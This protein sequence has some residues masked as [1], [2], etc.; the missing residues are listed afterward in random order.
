MFGKKNLP[1][2]P[3]FSSG[4]ARLLSTISTGSHCVIPLHSVVKPLFGPNFVSHFFNIKQH[5]QF[6]KLIKG[7]IE[8]SDEQKMQFLS[9]FAGKSTD[10]NA[11]FEARDKIEE[12]LQQLKELVAKC[13][14]FV[15]EIRSLDVYEKDGMQLHH[16]LIDVETAEATYRKQ[17]A[18][19][20][21][22]DIETLVGLLPEDATVLLIGP[23]RAQLYDSTKDA[24]PDVEEIYEIFK[25]VSCAKCM[26]ITKILCGVPEVHKLIQANG[27]LTITGRALFFIYMYESHFKKFAAE[28]AGAGAGAGSK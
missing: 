4:S 5:I 6:I 28:L 8:L 21:A 3:V 23:I 9:G 13:K 14:H 18:G 2:F 20:L 7:E 1:M 15:F 24:M 22:D 12:N 27:E 16:E 11:L 25:S 17:S 10:A 19:E 26:D